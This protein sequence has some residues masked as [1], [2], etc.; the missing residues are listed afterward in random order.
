MA[1][2]GARYFGPFTDVGGMRRIL[3]HV[4]RV[5]QV[6][7]CDLDLP[8]QTVPRPCLDYQIKRCPAP[9]VD[10]EDQATYRRRA[11]AMTRFLEGDPAPVLE[12]WTR[13]M[14]SLAAEHRFEA[15]AEVR[16]RIDLLTRM[17]RNM[18]RI[19]GIDTD[20]DVCA[21]AR[22]GTDG[23]GV[24]MRIRGG[25]IRSTADF[26]FEDRLQQE[27]AG[28]MAQLLREY[29]PR[30]GERPPLVL[31]SHDPG[32]L[33]IWEHWLGELGKGRFKLAVP[34]RGAKL[35]AVQLALRNATHKL[36]ER[37]LIRGDASRRIAPGTTTDLQEALGLHRIPETM[38]CFDI[39]TI[40]GHHTVG[41]MVYFKGGKPLKS[42]YRRFRI[43][44]VEGSDDYASMRE[45][46]SR[47]Y[48]KAAKDG[49]RPADLVI[50]DGGKG[51]LGVA[52]EVLGEQGF[53]DAEIIGL[54]KREETV[55]FPDG[56]Q[57]SL[58]ANSPALKLLQRIR[59]EAHRFAITYHRNVRKRDTL[60]SELDLIPGIGPI[61]KLA[62]LHHFGSLSSIRAA[63]ANALRE[64]RGI[65]PADARR[66]LDYFNTAAVE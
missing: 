31:L 28:F 63:D 41:S 50:V 14:K 2:D 10:Y 30:S 43:R 61:K 33:P 12:A 6:R 18:G 21:V 44:T 46:L 59:D 15:A 42:R 38:E 16:D 5:F 47:H 11:E 60:A 55:H 27:T 13:E 23:C 65:G 66:I 19:Q 37:R 58:P 62:L 40:G 17:I 7:T 52:R 48:G 4:L 35:D 20:L 26:H 56:A 29:Y 32:D 36:N 45:V 51:Q 1:D 49:A 24:V 25:R 22:D 8:G 64:V 34:R 53:G 3:S 54:A 57:I 39:S 9:C